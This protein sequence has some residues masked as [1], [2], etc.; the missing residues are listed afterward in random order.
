VV[1]CPLS[2]ENRDIDQ[3]SSPSPENSF[4]LQCVIMKSG[5]HWCSRGWGCKHTP[6]NVWL[7]QNLGKMSRKSGT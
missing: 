1:E 3:L 7:V 2:V 6:Q 4:I 5:G